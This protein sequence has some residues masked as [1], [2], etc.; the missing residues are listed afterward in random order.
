M[1]AE[2]GRPQL[3][4]L[5][6][7]DDEQIR[8][9]LLSVLNSEGHRVREAFNGTQAL[10]ALAVREPD[11]LILDLGLP[12]MSGFEVC[13]EVRLA[14]TVPV[15]VLTVRD[16]EDDKIRALDLGADDYLTKPFS[17]G[18]LLARIRAILRRVSPATEPDRVDFGDLEFDFAEQRV[19]R[20]GER[21]ALTRTEWQIVSY[22]ARRPGRVVPS[23]MIIAN[24][25]GPDSRIDVQVLRVHMSNARRKIEKNPALPR[26]ILTEPGVG[27]RFME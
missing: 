17:P 18:E 24:V 11:V 12:D 22:L 15:L 14:S 6:A 26:H 10:E 4:I 8:Y 7:D 25:W 1:L 23:Q 20:D 9:A 2:P 19:C 16:S 3:D 5:I 13:R 21:I 27:F